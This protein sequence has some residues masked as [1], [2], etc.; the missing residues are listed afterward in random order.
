MLRLIGFADLEEN[1]WYSLFGNV[2]DGLVPDMKFR[3]MHTFKINQF[4]SYIVV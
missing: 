2:A 1:T 3:A 4:I